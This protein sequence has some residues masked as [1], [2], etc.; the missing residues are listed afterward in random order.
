MK[1]NGTPLRGVGLRFVVA[2]ILKRAN[3]PV[4][5]SEIVET[6]VSQGFTFTTRP[7]K[8][9]SDCLRTE[10]NRR[11]ARRLSRGVY[12]FGFTSKSTHRR[13]RAMAEACRTYIVAT[14]RSQHPPWVDHLWVWRI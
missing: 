4:K 10:V 2:D 12:V 7:S 11:R 3:R 14:T 8:A 6:L 1:P 13:I 9:V 5:V